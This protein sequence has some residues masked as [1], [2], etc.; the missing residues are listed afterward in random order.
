MSAYLTAVEAAAHLKFPSVGAF[1]T[2]LY[3]RR[4]AGHPVTT[5]RRNGRLLFIVADLDAALTV[6]QAPTHLRKRA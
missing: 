4:K 1:R 3:R 6:E 5:H 2:F